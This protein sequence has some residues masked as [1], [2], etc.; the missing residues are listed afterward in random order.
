MG[1]WCKVHAQEIF[2]SENFL[3]SVLGSKP[4]I[5]LV[6]TEPC[7]TQPTPA[8]GNAIKSTCDQAIAN[9]TYLV[10]SQ[11]IAKSKKSKSTVLSGECGHRLM[12][13]PGGQ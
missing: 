8:S 4:V 10:T 11:K 6:E 9:V 3:G 2:R 7:P 13:H 5:L 12:V 1:F